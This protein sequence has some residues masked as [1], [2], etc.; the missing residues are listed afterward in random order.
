MSLYDFQQIFKYPADV[1][2][3]EEIP[4]SKVVGGRP[5]VQY[6]FHKKKQNRQDHEVR[7][8]V[9]TGHA[10]SAF[11]STEVFN[12]RGQG[13]VVNVGEYIVYISGPILVRHTLVLADRSARKLARN[14]LE[15]L[16]HQGFMSLG[17]FHF[18]TESWYHPLLV[19]GMGMYTIALKEL[20]KCEIMTDVIKL[21]AEN[22][23]NVLAIDNVANATANL[24][25]QF[26]LYDQKDR[27]HPRRRAVLLANNGI[28][29][30]NL[31]ELLGARAGGHRLASMSLKVKVKRSSMVAI[32]SPARFVVTETYQA[33]YDEY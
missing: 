17:N 27:D 15:I 30:E 9:L 4:G 20:V 5:G 22:R 3:V 32:E 25:T 24:I 12:A 16:F 18:D 33:I 8:C 2:F 26:V 19:R 11:V 14:E 21:R 31:A 28:Y 1:D 29:N 6:T 13:A 10:K 7:G 23:L